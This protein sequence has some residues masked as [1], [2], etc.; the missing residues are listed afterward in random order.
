MLEINCIA[1]FHINSIF[2]LQICSCIYILPQI[3]EMASQQ[4][5]AVRRDSDVAGK[6]SANGEDA[7]TVSDP[8]STNPHDVTVEEDVAVEFLYRVLNGS[9][10]GDQ[11]PPLHSKIV[12]IFTSSTFTGEMR[13][14][15]D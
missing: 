1:Y 15:L 2:I 3:A 12:R 7:T 10:D 5:E 11:L 4:N 14:G 13:V 8:A 6:A 9:L